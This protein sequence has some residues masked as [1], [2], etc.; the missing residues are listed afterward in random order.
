[1]S[2]RH[3][4]SSQRTRRPWCHGTAQAP[5]HAEDETSGWTV[6]TAERLLD[7]A[8]ELT[9]D[10]LPHLSAMAGAYGFIATIA[11]LVDATGADSAKLVLAEPR[12]WRPEDTLGLIVVPPGAEPGD[13]IVFT[14]PRAGH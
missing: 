1:M 7:F 11:T 8:A 12:M 13:A 10:T 14:R 4:D 6:V 2:S 3:R 5:D 9:E